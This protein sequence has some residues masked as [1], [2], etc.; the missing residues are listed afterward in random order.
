MTR[1]KT[2][3]S[4]EPKQNSPPLPVYIVWK[5]RFQGSGKSFILYGVYDGKIAQHRKKSCANSAANYAR[6][7]SGRLIVLKNCRSAN[8]REGENQFVDRA[9]CF[10]CFPCARQ[11]ENATLRGFFHCFRILKTAGP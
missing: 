3:R 4:P 7:T 5:S 1:N 10:C 2:F 11:Q 9:M 6:I 8:G